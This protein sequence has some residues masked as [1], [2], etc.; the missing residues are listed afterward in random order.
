LKKLESVLGRNV[1]YNTLCHTSKVLAG[2]SFDIPCIEEEL[3]AGDLM[4]FKYQ[5]F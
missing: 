3:T 1:G 4:Y 2:E 5:Y